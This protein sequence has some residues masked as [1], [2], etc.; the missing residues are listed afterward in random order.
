M[1]QSNTETDY[2]INSFEPINVCSILCK[3]IHCEIATNI[4]FQYTFANALKIVAF[5]N[6]FTL[7]VPLLPL[8]VR[9]IC[10]DNWLRDFTACTSSTAINDG[11]VQYRTT[12]TSH[13][14][15]HT[16]LDYEDKSAACVFCIPFWSLSII[17][18]IG[19][20]LCYHNLINTKVLYL[21]Y[22]YFNTYHYLCLFFL[23]QTKRY[24][25]GRIYD[26]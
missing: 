2:I 7:S 5:I 12:T 18:I 24:S 4:T 25:M 26:K 21:H 19:R 14:Q 3:V 15:L 10:S 6:L 9:L 22:D 20:S 23:N 11:L 1:I 8:Y 13:K 17:F 16:C